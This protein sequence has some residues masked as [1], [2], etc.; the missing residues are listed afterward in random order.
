VSATL[1]TAIHVPGERC[2]E[3]VPM[4]RDEE[5]RQ[6]VANPMQV[7]REQA[8]GLE[9]LTDH[10]SPRIGRLPD[11][12]ELSVIRWELTAMHVRAKELV[13]ATAAGD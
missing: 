11:G 6:V 5:P 1:T 7:L 8:V 9:R 13:P 4:F 3:E 2:V 10:V 12:A